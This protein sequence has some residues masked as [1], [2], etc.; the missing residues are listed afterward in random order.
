[1]R[2]GFALETCDKTLVKL[3]R[4]LFIFAD[5]SLDL[6]EQLGDEVSAE[7]VVLCT[8]EDSHVDQLLQGVAL[9]ELDE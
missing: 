1:M 6:S 5:I 2:Q 3:T 9:E 7:G 8:S 4:V